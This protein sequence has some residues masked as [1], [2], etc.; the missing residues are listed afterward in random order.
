MTWAHAH[1]HAHKP[2]CTRR[3]RAYRAP[4]RRPVA[5]C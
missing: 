3:T 2:H 4:W 1:A 5:A